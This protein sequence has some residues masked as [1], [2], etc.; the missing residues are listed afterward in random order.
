MGEEFVW[1]CKNGDL[2]Q[3]RAIAEKPGFYVNAEILNGRNG[4]H[5]AADYGHSNIIEYLLSKG[6]DI[7]RP[8]KYNITPLLASIFEGKTDCVKLLLEKGAD[9]TLKA[10]DGSSYIECA[11]T[12]EIKSLLK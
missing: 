8:D 5:F 6:A 12:D 7:N 1:A 3:V 10:P 2:D 4:V 9:K 11:E